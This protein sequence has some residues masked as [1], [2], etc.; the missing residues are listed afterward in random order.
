MQ[1]ERPLSPHLQIYKMQ[2]LTSLLSFAHRST[3]IVLVF[4]TLLL[5]YWLTA[6]AAGPQA[7]AQLQDYLSHWFVLLLLVAWTFCLF[8]HLC[9]GIRHLFWDIGKGFEIEAVYKSGTVVVIVA[10]VLTLAT[11]LAA[12]NGGL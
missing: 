1:K 2:Q 11:L 12:F 6:I 8:Y 3:G 9:N 10:S 5:V 7:Y 4:G